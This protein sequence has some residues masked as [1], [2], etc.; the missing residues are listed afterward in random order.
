MNYR[1]ITNEIAQIGRDHKKNF[2]R[3]AFVPFLGIV[4]QLII[5]S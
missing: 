2:S 5:R 1:L 3:I 4:N